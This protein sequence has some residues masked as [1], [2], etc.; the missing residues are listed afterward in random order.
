MA[1]RRLWF[2][3]YKLRLEDYRKRHP[4]GIKRE[5]ESIFF[6]PFC[7]MSINKSEY[8]KHLLLHNDQRG[9]KPDNWN[10]FKLFNTFVIINEQLNKGETFV[11]ILREVNGHWYESS[12]NGYLSSIFNIFIDK[13]NKVGILKRKR[14]R[15]II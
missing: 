2:E 1:S 12:W 7:A 11:P 8:A 15:R 3:T 6:C 4:T 5:D 10:I 13:N 9:T 14:F